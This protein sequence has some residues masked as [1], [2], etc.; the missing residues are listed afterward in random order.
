MNQLQVWQVP[1]DFLVQFFTN[2]SSEPLLTFFFFF[3]RVCLCAS[4]M[5]RSSK[6]NNFLKDP[7]LVLLRVGPVNQAKAVRLGSRCLHPWSQLASPHSQGLQ[8][9][10]PTPAFSRL[11]TLKVFYN[12]SPPPVPPHSPAPPTSPTPPARPQPGFVQKVCLSSQQVDCE[13]Q[14]CLDLVSRAKKLGRGLSG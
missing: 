12:S 13:P 2:I 6:S 14:L 8:P 11:H 5:V 1:V 10:P 3:L 9:Q 4:S 7:E